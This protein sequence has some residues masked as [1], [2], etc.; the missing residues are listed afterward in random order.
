VDEEL[1][2]KGRVNYLLLKQAE[3]GSERIHTA[4]VQECGGFVNRL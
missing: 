3:A 4:R 1:N 2:V